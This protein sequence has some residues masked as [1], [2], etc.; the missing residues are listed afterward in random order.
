[1]IHIHVISLEKLVL[2]L[3]MLAPLLSPEMSP[4]MS[5]F[6]CFCSQITALIATGDLATGLREPCL[7]RCVCRRVWK[8]THFEGHV[9]GLVKTVLKHTH[10]E[11]ILFIVHTHI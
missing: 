4:E 1:M 7:P 11:G 8:R 6:H 3:E 2:S 10:N 5:P 9:D